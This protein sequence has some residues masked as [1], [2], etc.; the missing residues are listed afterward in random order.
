MV[1]DPD[2][3]REDGKT[4]NVF[5][6]S[7]CLICGAAG[8]GYF[9]LGAKQLQSLPLYFFFLF[10]TFHGIFINYAIAKIQDSRAKFFS[11]DPVWGA[12]GFLDLSQ[13]FIAFV[14]YGIFCTF[15]GNVGYIFATIFF[16]PVV[17]ASCLLVEP[18]LA[19]VFGYLWG[20]DKFPGF[21]T[22]MGG[23]V[24]IFGLF[25]LQMS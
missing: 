1:L 13:I 25:M 5:V 17:T 21:L 19:Q 20:I 24:A 6:Y 3:Q 4:G 22:I 23:L 16:S 12:F 2:A 15:F 14:P 9:L 8:A 11:T 18:P 7:V 10:V